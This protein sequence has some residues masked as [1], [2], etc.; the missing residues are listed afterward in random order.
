[1]EQEEGQPDFTEDGAPDGAMSHWFSGLT[2]MEAP[3]A[4]MPDWMMESLWNNVPQRGTQGYAHN[5]NMFAPVIGKFFINSTNYG[6]LIS[7]IYNFKS[8][9]EFT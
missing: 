8:F 3:R 7:D 9:L 2:E 5:D 4:A 6:G 1:M